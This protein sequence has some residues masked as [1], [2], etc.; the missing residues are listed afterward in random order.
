M[1][2]PKP[3]VVPLFPPNKPLSKPARSLALAEGDELSL[4]P[5]KVVDEPEPWPLLEPELVGA[6]DAAAEVKP[7]DT[8]SATLLAAEAAAGEVPAGAAAVVSGAA[9][10]AG[11]ETDT[12]G[13]GE[14]AAGAA[15]CVVGAAAVSG[16]GT[17]DTAT[18][19]LGASAA[20]VGGAAADDESAGTAG[21]P[22]AKLANTTVVASVEKKRIVVVR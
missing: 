19:W 16:A 8:A 7:L 13:D 22:T 14:A 10:A 1:R 6:A 11:T 9:A 17:V 18:G 3:P 12:T 5:E 4:L 2:L 20:L 21:E 15:G